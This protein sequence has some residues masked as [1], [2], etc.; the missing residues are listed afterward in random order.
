MVFLFGNPQTVHSI[1]HSLL[2]PARQSPWKR[3]SRGARFRSSPRLFRPFPF[4]LTQ[5]PSLVVLFTISPFFLI[6]QGQSLPLFFLLLCP[7][8][9]SFF[10]CGG[11][12]GE[13]LA[14]PR[15]ALP[16]HLGPIQPPE[17]EEGH[18]AVRRGGRD[19]GAYSKIPQEK[20]YLYSNLSKWRGGFGCG[21]CKTNGI[22]FLLVGEFP[23]HFSRDFSGDWDVHWGYGILTHGHL[24]GTTCS[25]R[26]C[27]YW[28]QMGAG[29][30]PSAAKEKKKCHLSYHASLARVSSISVSVQA[31]KSAE[32]RCSLWAPHFGWILKGSLKGINQV[33][34]SNCFE[35]NQP[36]RSG[37]LAP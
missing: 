1:P 29:H 23:T 13:L 14:S 8:M 27:F 19:G 4:L 7:T 22:P 33:W 5:G 18:G 34:C 15:H 17:L 3:F 32:S 12:G 37:P 24:S 25:P 6:F 16:R 20:G 35:T 11:G 26:C 36:L 10:F 9:S 21:G 28:L 2:A 31:S 30:I